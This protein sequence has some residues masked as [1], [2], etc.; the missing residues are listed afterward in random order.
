MFESVFKKC[1][2]WLIKNALIAQLWLK[3]LSKENL[4]RQIK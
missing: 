3:L 1:L 2:E 4:I